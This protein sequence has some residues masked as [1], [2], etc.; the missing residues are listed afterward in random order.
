MEGV[1]SRIFA[2]E[3]LVEQGAQAIEVALW[4]SLL[5]AVL[6]RGS[7]AWG[8][9]RD[10]I[11]GLSGFEVAR[12]TEVDQEE[13]PFGGAHNVGGLEV[14]KDDRWLACMQIVQY[15]AELQP[16]AAYFV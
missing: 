9:Q 4:R 13:M 14:A 8:A 2:R 6:F 15:F 1:L 3:Q 7:V 10:R 5:F 16:D 11:P 12:N